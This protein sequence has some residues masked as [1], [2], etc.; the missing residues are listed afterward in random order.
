MVLSQTPSVCESLSFAFPAIKRFPK[1][2]KKKVP[3]VFHGFEIIMLILSWSSHLLCQ[4]L[5]SLFKEG[6]ISSEQV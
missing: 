1:G 6:G 5:W 4:M 3:F 2:K